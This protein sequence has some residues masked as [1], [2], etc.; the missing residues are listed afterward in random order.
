M[1]FSLSSVIKPTDSLDPESDSSEPSSGEESD[2]ESEEDAPTPKA[3]TMEVGGTNAPSVPESRSPA[4]SSQTLV[5]VKSSVESDS[6]SESSRSSTSVDDSTSSSDSDSDNTFDT[7]KKSIPEK[8]KSQK[9][10]VVDAPNTPKPDGRTAVTKRRRMDESGSSVPTSVLQQPKAFNPHKKGN[11]KGQPR[12]SNTPF[13]R[14]KVDE[15]KFADERLKDNTFGSR[16]AAANDYGAKASADLAV[17]RGASFRKEKNKKKR[18]SY[19][20]GDITVRRTASE[21]FSQY[22]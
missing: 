18:G 7:G 21:G 5:S 9:A 19:R 6:D 17:T 16:K 1:V 2:S 11:G 20:G 22:Y 3:M 12:N 15:V 10:K 14:I 8:D 4:G 13:S